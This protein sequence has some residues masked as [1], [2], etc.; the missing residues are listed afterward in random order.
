MTGFIEDPVA[1]EA[2]F[3]APDGPV[4]MMLEELGKQGVAAAQR[5]CPVGSDPN[6]VPG[7]LRDSIR[8][9]VEEAGPVVNIGSSLPYAAYVEFGTFDQSPQPFLRPAMMGLKP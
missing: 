3:N 9:V 8:Y 1:I 2:L 5:M 7:A 4:W 6:D